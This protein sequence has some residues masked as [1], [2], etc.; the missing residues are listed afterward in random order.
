MYSVVLCSQRALNYTGVQSCVGLQ[1]RPAP[2][3]TRP[4]LRYIKPVFSCADCLP[5][6]ASLLYGRTQRESLWRPTN[7]PPV[8]TLQIYLRCH[9][10]RSGVIAA[11]QLCISSRG[12]CSWMNT[13][14]RS[15]RNLSGNSYTSDHTVSDNERV[16]DLSNSDLLKPSV[17]ETSK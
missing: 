4:T 5:I 7:E 17:N 6:V 10:S 12:S 14:L 1:E 3:I 15:R 2:W 8:A 9:C 13:I 11:L 16:F